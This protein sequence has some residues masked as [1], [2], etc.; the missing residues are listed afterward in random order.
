MFLIIHELSGCS[1]HYILVSE[2][3]HMC[4]HYNV[5]SLCNFEYFKFAIIKSF[6]MLTQFKSSEMLN[7]QNL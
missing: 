5:R 2:Q 3:K 4:V 7:I 1:T 6:R